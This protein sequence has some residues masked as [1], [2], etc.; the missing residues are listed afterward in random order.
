MR[1]RWPATTIPSL[2]SRHTTSA[3]GQPVGTNPALAVEVPG[4]RRVSG[5]WLGAV[6]TPWFV[7]L[8]LVNGGG[9]L[10][11]DI[12]AGERRHVS[13]PC[14]TLLFVVTVDPEIGPYQYNSLVAEVR[15]LPDMAVTRQV[16]G[17][18]R[19]PPGAGNRFPPRL[20]A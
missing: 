4:F 2:A 18:G 5:D 8:F 12:P 7:R 9:A 3:C 6:V 10:W 13:L 15:S 1:R 16:A 17:G 19:P 11:G 14:R 20:F